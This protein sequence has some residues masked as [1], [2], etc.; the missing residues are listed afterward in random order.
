MKT[1]PNEMPKATAILADGL[2][3]VGNV[4]PLKYSPDK[5]GVQ[6]RNLP[7]VATPLIDHHIFDVSLFVA[8]TSR[9]QATLMR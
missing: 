5:N 8:N 6:Y 4:A 2:L 7:H 3:N 9:D 1:H